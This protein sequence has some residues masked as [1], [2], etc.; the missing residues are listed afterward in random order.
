M[1]RK[2]YAFDENKI[3]RFLKEGRGEGTGVSYRPWLTIQDV[4]SL[5][6]S[7]RLCGWKT[8]RVHHLL[9]DI[10]CSLFYLFDWSD[11]VQDIREQFPIDR[12]TTQRIAEQLGIRHPTDITTKTP[13]VM[14][15]DIVVDVVRDGRSVILA[16]AVKPANLLDK[17][18]IIEKLEIERR[19]WLERGAEWG[20]VT[21][22]DIPKT[23]VRNVA[24]VHNFISLDQLSQLHPGYLAEKAA[25]VLQEISGWTGDR[26]LSDFCGGMDAHFAVPSGTCLMLVRH[27]LATK[28]LSCDMTKSL[29][30]T[31]SVG[32]LRAVSTEFGRATG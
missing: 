29:D 13:L 21:E 11:S 28:R 9:S 17:P 3:A 6:R 16:R 8:G 18:R 20:I 7:H 5:G 31:A 15:T 10:E 26:P 12:Q 24:W 23:V 14:T 2:R 27:L 32:R 25:Q 19:Y 4:P 30:D 22:R 1:A